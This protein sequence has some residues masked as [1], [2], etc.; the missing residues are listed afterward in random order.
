V[1]LQEATTNG[2]V[3]M[4]SL[5]ITPCMQSADALIET[6]TSELS[7]LCTSAMVPPLKRV[8]ITAFW[9]NCFFFCRDVQ[10]DDYGLFVGVVYRAVLLCYA[11]NRVGM[12]R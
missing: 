2:V 12:W 6:L 11:L 7:R 9:S 5:P 10:G 3:S 8:S 4:K 1:A